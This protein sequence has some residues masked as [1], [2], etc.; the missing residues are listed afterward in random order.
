VEVAEVMRVLTGKVQGPIVE[1]SAALGGVLL[2]GAGLAKDRA[3]GAAKITQAITSGAAAERFGAM[4]AALGGPVQ[5]V[6]HWQRFLPEATVM[7]E[8]TAQTSGVVQ[9]MDAQALGEA[10]VALGGGRMIESDAVD[11]AVGL[12][13][14]VRVGARVEKGQPLAVVHASRSQQ[15]DRAAEAVRSAITLGAAGAAPDLIVEHIT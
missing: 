6:E 8:V 15:A 2:A 1:L 4:I 9:E 13:E 7:R 14:V 11:P 10:V 3:D 5:F 12:S